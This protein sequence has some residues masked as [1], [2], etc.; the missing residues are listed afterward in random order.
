M[1]VQQH[2]H[3]GAMKSAPRSLSDEQLRRLIS[4]TKEDQR[5][6]DLHDVVTVISNTGIRAGELRALRWADIDL[7]KR[8]IILN[9]GKTG[10]RPMP[11]GPKTLQVLAARREREPE[12]EYVLGSLPGVSLFVFHGNYAQFAIVLA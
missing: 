8:Q 2:Q 3:L 11:F 5:L 1:S 9:E 10:K 6:R 7:H 12:S 4:R